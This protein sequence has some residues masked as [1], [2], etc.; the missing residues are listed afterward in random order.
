M[1]QNALLLMVGAAVVGLIA[2]VLILRRQRHESE[3]ADRESPLAV[4]TEGEKICPKC[5]GANLWTE[6]TCIYCQGPLR[7]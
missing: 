1:D 7:G 4:S 5:G 2:I 6:K 3:D